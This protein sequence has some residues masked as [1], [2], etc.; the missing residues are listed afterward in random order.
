MSYLANIIGSA[1]MLQISSRNKKS[2]KVAT[3][4]WENILKFFERSREYSVSTAVE[5]EEEIKSKKAT[6][7][8]NQLL[9]VVPAV[10]VKK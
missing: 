2:F 1:I 3:K 10:K 4:Q 5:D 6:K 9:S 7:V 8:L